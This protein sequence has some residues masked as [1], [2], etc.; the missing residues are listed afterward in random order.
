MH[1]AEQNKVMFPHVFTQ[2]E[3]NTDGTLVLGLRSVPGEE[4]RECS[5][6]DAM[7]QYRYIQEALDE[8]S[9][10]YSSITSITYA[11][12]KD[13]TI[14][15]IFGSGET[16]VIALTWGIPRALLARNWFYTFASGGHSPL[17]NS[18]PHIQELHDALNDDTLTNLTY[19][20]GD[21]GWAVTSCRRDVAET[22][23]LPSHRRRVASHLTEL[24]R[25]AR[26][27]S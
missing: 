26:H 15:H 7:Y 4:S 6:E 22:P 24:L 11:S 25:L 13:S 21:N 12:D 18:L 10:D 19:A 20:W 5:R 9:V 23:E 14:C 16:P 3:V 1:E 17:F 8:H 27:G 2:Y